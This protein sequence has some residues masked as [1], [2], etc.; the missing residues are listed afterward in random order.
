[1]AVVG[2]R[3]GINEEDVTGRVITRSKSSI[4]KKRRQG[5]QHVGSGDGQGSIATIGERGWKPRLG[6]REG[7]GREGNAKGCVWKRA[8]SYARRE[9]EEEMRGEGRHM[10]IYIEHTEGSGVIESPSTWVGR[11]S[12]QQ[13]YP[14]RLQSPILHS[15]FRLPFSRCAPSKYS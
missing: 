10:A 4:A 9:S 7:K 6:G 2:N 5:R 15:S 12:D 11:A 13:R 8:S 14:S 1:V 3:W